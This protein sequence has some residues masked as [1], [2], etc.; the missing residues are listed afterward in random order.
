[1]RCFHVP[2]IQEFQMEFEWF[3]LIPQLPQIIFLKV[4]IASNWKN[5]LLFV[6]VEKERRNSIDLKKN[7][8]GFDLFLHAHE[9]AYT[10]V[11]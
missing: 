4:W 5:H 8:Q 1:M 11:P 9:E 7:D 2:L 3:Y 10:E 6:K